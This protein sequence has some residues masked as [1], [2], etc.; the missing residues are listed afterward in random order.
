MNGTQS[1]IGLP[2]SKTSRKEWRA[3]CRDSVLECGSP[4]PL[5]LLALAHI[6]PFIGFMPPVFGVWNLLVGGY[7]CPLAFASAIAV[8]SRRSAR[9]QSNGSS[10][11]DSTR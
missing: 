10:N 6:A 7:Y 1:G 2:H 9:L 5:S 11:R 4:M 3:I 8:F